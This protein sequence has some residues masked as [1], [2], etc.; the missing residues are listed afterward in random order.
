[1]KPALSSIDHLPPQAFKTGQPCERPHAGTLPGVV[2]VA[3]EGA[4]FC[5]NCQHDLGVRG[6]SGCCK[7]HLSEFFGDEPCDVGGDVDHGCCYH[8]EGEVGE[9]DSHGF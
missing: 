8:D 5:A 2:A 3:G 1:M 7:Q 9:A 6:C 4:F